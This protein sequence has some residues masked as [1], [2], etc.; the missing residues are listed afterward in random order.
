MLVPIT[1]SEFESVTV[2]VP[3][4]NIVS[5]PLEPKLIGVPSMVVGVMPGTM[6]VPVAVIGA[7][8]IVASVVCDGGSPLGLGGL[9]VSVASG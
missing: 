2:L 1:C 7:S 8:D 6:A 3:M 4:T 9:D 5:V